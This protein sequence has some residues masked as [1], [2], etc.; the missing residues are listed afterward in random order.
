[1][2]LRSMDFGTPDQW[3]AGN[4]PVP[5]PQQAATK[6]RRC[7]QN[8]FELTNTKA[9]VVFAFFG[10]NESFAG[11]AGLAKFKK[12]LD[13]FI[14]H[15]LGQKYN[16]KTRPAARPVLADRPRGPAR[17]QPARRQGEQRAA[18]SCTPPPWP[19]SP[20]RT[21][22]RSSICSRRRSELYAKAEQAADDQRRPPERA[23][24]PAASP[25]VIDTALFGERRPQARRRK[26]SRSS[27]QAVARQELPLVQPLPHRRRL[28]DLRRP[29]RS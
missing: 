8:R 23:R 25:Q 9:D 29:G 22:C 2:R 13:D 12:D 21:A 14:K 28:L 11:E 20:R 1:M 10:Y 7:A 5:Q 16:G 19:R 27:A 17:P 4:A 3:L 26:R 6:Q 18:R 24:Q 15:T